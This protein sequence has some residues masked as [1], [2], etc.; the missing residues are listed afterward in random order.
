MNT[1]HSADSTYR[2]LIQ[3]IQD[4]AIYL[5]SPDGMVINWNPGAQHAKGYTAQ[6]IIGR[7]FSCFYTP[8]DRANHLPAFALATALNSG[9]FEGEGWRVRKDGTRFWAHVVIDPVYDEDGTHIG[10][11]KVTRDRT[12]WK[13]NLD[14]L[15]GT[16]EMLSTALSNMSEGLCLF[17]A[18]EQIVLFNERFPQILG[19]QPSQVQVGDNLR[20]L[21]LLRNQRLV[22][23]ESLESTADSELDAFRNDLSSAVGVVSHERFWDGRTIAVNHNRLPDGG[24][25]T[26]VEDVTERKRIEHQI[27]HL[28]LHD[29]LTDLN[30]RSY[31]NEQLESRLEAD[32]PCTLLYIDLDRF[33]PINDTLGHSAGD[34]V[35]QTIADRLRLQLRQ[36]DVGA[37]LGGDE[38]AI[39][40]TGCASIEDATSVAER[41]LRDIERPINTGSSTVTISA[42]IGI[43][44]SPLHGSFTAVLHRNADLALYNAKQSGRGRVCVFDESLQD[45]LAQRHSLERDLRLALDRKEFFLHYQPVLDVQHDL[46][47]GFEALLRW[48]S[49]TRGNVSPAEFIPFAEEIGLM[50]EIGDWVLHTACAE[51]VTWDNPVGISVN[52]SP[53][54]FRQP[55]LVARIAGTLR[56]TGLS[57]SRLELEITETA[58]IGD[59]PGAKAILLELR[60]LGIQIAMDDFG[61]GYSSLSFLR[62]LPF[63]RIKID[64]SFVQ[65]LGTKA[66]A[67]A[68]IRAV[69][70]L[71]LG[72]GVSATAEGVE[73]E[74]Q[75][76]I[77]REEGCGEVQGYFIHR[78]AEASV[79][80]A[81]LSAYSHQPT[82][83]RDTVPHP[84]PE[85]TKSGSFAICA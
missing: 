39:L 65:D 11:A 19:L 15:N 27:V 69:T 83:N 31:F 85:G 41:L 22:S 53:T 84:K 74:E 62:N 50:A 43:T 33:K 42:S 72:L 26:T 77:L 14:E 51:A 66:E 79:A 38:F 82:A 13:R 60:S 47:T 10:F 44:V 17:N 2:L 28:A 30:N 71:C 7:H 12:E 23:A 36:N 35:L 57:A 9:K 25:V 8:E 40:L 21:L 54:Q 6:E 68:I 73:T 29:P 37:R 45:S 55:D 78:P 56:S 3:S 24:W 64:R 59:L 1:I 75:M 67:V 46:V 16:R 48:S 20:Y 80:T 4:L 70:G 5:L 18:H 49:P 34:K 61:T 32:V 76:R 58:M 81:W 63:T 52:L